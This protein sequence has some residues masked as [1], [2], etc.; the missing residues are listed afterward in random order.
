MHTIRLR[1]PWSRQLDGQPTADKVD[2]PDDRP[3]PVSAGRRVT[4]RRS[5]NRPTGLAADDR[6]WLA[7][8]PCAASA[9]EILIN[10]ISI[11]QSAADQPIRVDITRHLEPANQLVLQLAGDPAGQAH[12]AGPVHLQIATAAP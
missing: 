6:V 1:R 4:Y 10:G 3:V 5:F 2:V 9:I 12:L 7:I 8:D 11:H